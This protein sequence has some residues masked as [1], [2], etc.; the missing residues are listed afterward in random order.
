MTFEEFARSEGVRLRAAL[1]AAYGAQAGLD[2]AAE[3]IAYGRE[4]WARHPI[5]ASL[6]SVQP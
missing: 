2:A 4:H 1:V 5:P 3:A 6:T